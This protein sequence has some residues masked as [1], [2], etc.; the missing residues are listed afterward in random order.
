MNFELSALWILI[1]DGQITSLPIKCAMKFNKTFI[2]TFFKVNIF[3]LILLY[4]K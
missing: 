3:D 4:V 1:F 2:V